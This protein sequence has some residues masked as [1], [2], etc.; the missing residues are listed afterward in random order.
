[1]SGYTVYEVDVTNGESVVFVNSIRARNLV[2]FLWLWRRLP[3]M[4]RSIRREPGAYECI[5]A[6]V[7]PWQVVMVSYWY[8]SREL[9][10]YYR[11]EAHVE[12]TAFLGKH[13]QSLAMFFE[14][15]PARHSGK[16]VNGTFGLGR[17]F[18]RKMP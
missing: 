13:P 8:S 7:S 18:R 15:F 12:W 3:R 2:G 5:P 16:Y 1:M 6:L 9:G 17:N 4:I 10:G 14:Q 11:G